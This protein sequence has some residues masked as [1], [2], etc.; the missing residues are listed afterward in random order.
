M[1]LT[2]ATD[3]VRTFLRC[4]ITLQDLLA[5]LADACPED[6]FP[7]ESP[8]AVVL[9]MA[10]GSVGTR[11]RRV[12]AEDFARAAELMELAV[13]AVLADLR[14]AVEVAGRRERGY[15]VVGE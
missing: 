7:G 11:L 8:T 1:E 10:I 12:P 9:E 14:T 6:A 4:G 15:R 5:D 2:P 13:E 3:F